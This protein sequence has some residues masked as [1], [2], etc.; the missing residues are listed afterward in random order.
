VDTPA[1]S[2]LRESGRARQTSDLTY[3]QSIE[4]NGRHFLFRAIVFDDGSFEISIIDVTESENARRVKEEMTLRINKALIAHKLSLPKSDPDIE[5]QLCT[6]TYTATDR[7]VVYSKGN[8]HIVDA[9]RCALLR[10]A[11][12]LEPAYEP[13]VITVSFT[14]LLT[15]PIFD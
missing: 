1:L 12:T 2:A 11:Q 10:R 5:D 4:K 3:N 14:P 9:M 8:D 7:G 15:G 6:Q 13:T